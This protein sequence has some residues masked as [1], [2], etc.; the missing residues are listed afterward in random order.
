MAEVATARPK[1]ARS[2]SPSYADALASPLEVLLKRRRRTTWSAVTSGPPTWEEEV[3]SRPNSS[4]N[5]ETSS[6]LA[7]ASVPDYNDEDSCGAV[8]VERRRARQWE[9]LQA[10]QSSSQ[11]VTLPVLHDSSP[12]RYSR[13]RAMSQPEAAEQHMGFAVPAIQHMSS[14]PVRHQDPSSTPFRADDEWAPEE[15]LRAWGDEYASQNSLLYSLVRLDQYIADTS[16]WLGLRTLT[17]TTPTRHLTPHDLSIWGAPP[18]H[19]H[20]S[21]IPIARRLF[22]TAIAMPSAPLL[23]LPTWRPRPVRQCRH[24]RPSRMHLTHHLWHMNRRTSVQA[25]RRRT[26]CWPSST[27]RD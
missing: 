27:C 18:H 17:I 23:T 16:T 5:H 3:D 11:P 6:P 4:S 21:C 12:L 26:A 2:P 22:P 8:G 1:R 13:E 19:Q 25:T 14:S 7:R 10:P 9:R 20:T 15:R 24:S